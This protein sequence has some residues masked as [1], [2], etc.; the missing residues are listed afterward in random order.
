MI[1]TKTYFAVVNV[2]LSLVLDLLVEAAL[3]LSLLHHLKASLKPGIAH[4]GSVLRYILAVWGRILSVVTAL[5]QLKLL[6]LQLSDYW[7]R[8]LWLIWI[9]ARHVI[10]FS[11]CLY[12][13]AYV[14]CMS[15]RFTSAYQIRCHWLDLMVELLGVIDIV[16]WLTSIDRWR[17]LPHT[18]LWLILPAKISELGIHCQ[19]RLGWW[20]W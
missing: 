1:W 13:W 18:R 7:I 10:V 6:R 17:F 11:V 3:H 19:I 5:P 20:I 14:R 15:A 2:D 8:V 16:D 4:V 12:I 9:E